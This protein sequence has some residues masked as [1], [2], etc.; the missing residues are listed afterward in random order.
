LVRKITADMEG[1][2]QGGMG[3]QG[4][5]SKASVDGKESKSDEKSSSEEG[6]ISSSE[7]LKKEF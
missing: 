2:R 7:E 1:G 3:G 6:G 5:G 4:R